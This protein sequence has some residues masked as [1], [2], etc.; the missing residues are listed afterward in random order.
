[1]RA[2]QPRFAPILPTF[3]FFRLRLASGG[4]GRRLGPRRG[5]V[6]GARGSG[7]VVLPA[8]GAGAVGWFGVALGV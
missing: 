7:V 8:V 3:A 2:G 4:V 5:C 1:M 6:G